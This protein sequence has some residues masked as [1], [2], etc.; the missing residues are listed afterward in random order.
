MFFNRIRTLKAALLLIAS[1]GKAAFEIAAGKDIPKSF[2]TSHERND[3]KP[4]TL[5]RCE[6]HAGSDWITLQMNKD[7]FLNRPSS[8]S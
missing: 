5:L 3:E 1:G 7:Y 4:G 2:L 8:I 6:V